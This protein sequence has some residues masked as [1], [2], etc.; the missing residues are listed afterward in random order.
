MGAVDSKAV[1]AHAEIV[2]VAVAA[3]GL[4]LTPMEHAQR[5]HPFQLK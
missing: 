1:V 4:V 2:A 3:A 5:N